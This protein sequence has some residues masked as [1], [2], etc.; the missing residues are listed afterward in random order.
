[1][2]FRSRLGATADEVAAAAHA[3][4]AHSFITSFADGYE[5][6]VG[7]GGHSLSST[8][9]HHIALARAFLRNAPILVLDEPITDEGI[10]P[11]LRRLMAGRATLLISN[12]LKLARYADV[13][14]V[15]H[16]GRV[17]ESGPHEWLINHGAAYQNLHRENSNHGATAA[18]ISLPLQTAMN[19]QRELVN[20]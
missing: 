13:V 14:L 4:D 12:H 20:R 19:A 3:A 16:N 5:S 9:R 6:A 15:M 10:V 8:Q 7:R 17:I 18:P 2:L 11:A 1:M